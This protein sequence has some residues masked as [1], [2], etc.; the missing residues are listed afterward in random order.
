MNNLIL[1]AY[2]FLDKPSMLNF[3]LIG[4]PTALLFL[5]GYAIQGKFGYEKANI[6]K[7]RKVVGKI[8][9]YS[10]IPYFFITLIILLVR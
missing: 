6:S 1:L 7:T 4:I 9:F 10:A 3:A 8:V 2:K 5:I